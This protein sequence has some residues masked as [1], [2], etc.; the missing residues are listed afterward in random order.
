MKIRLSHLVMVFCCL[1]FV[2]EQNVNTSSLVSI[3]ILSLHKKK[4]FNPE[5][6]FYQHFDTNSKYYSRLKENVPD[7]L[8][9]ANISLI[10]GGFYL[11]D[12]I[13]SPISQA[14]LDNVQADFDILRK[15]GMKGV[16]RFSYTKNSKASVRDAKENFTGLFLIWII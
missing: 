14:Y 11:D 10:Y 12:F 3:A 4:I 1:S 6:G 13:N 7:T 2:G 16:I 9:R 8:K 15:V 5:R